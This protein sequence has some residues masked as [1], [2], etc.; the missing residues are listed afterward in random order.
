VARMEA[1]PGGSAIT[2]RHF[3]VAALVAAFPGFRFMSIEDGPARFIES[4]S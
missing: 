4:V 1:S 3:D 2:R